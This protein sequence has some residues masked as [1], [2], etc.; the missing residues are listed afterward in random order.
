[1]KRKSLPAKCTRL[2][3]TTHSSSSTHYTYLFTLVHFC[4]TFNVFPKRQGRGASSTYA[5][6]L[7]E[8]NE[9]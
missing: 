9:S 6:Y 3:D 4:A 2:T 7:Q 5:H 1:M 8:L